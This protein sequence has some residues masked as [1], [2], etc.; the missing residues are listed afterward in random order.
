M[1]KPGSDLAAD[2]GVTAQDDVMFAVFSAPDA[3]EGDITSKPS[4]DSALC[5]YSLKNIR[6]KFMSNI[7]RCFSG[8]GARGLDFISPRCV[9][10]VVV[11]VVCSCG[12][13]ATLSTSARETNECR[14]Q[15]V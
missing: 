5:V 10:V 12:C 1:G 7:Q 6:R 14:D 11:V 3:S 8:E 2:L 9:V 15:A 13:A 4:R